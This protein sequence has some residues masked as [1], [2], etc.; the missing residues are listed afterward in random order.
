MPLPTD[1]A[2]SEKPVTGSENTAVT[3]NA[4]LVGFDEL[5]EST[6][7]GRVAS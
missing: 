2:A 5:D 6:A 1:T 3:G 4:A 7:D